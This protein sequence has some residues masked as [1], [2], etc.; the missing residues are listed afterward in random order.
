VSRDAA[1]V[2]GERALASVSL[3][4]ALGGGWEA[5]PLTP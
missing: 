3:V 2:A 5:A 4:R 1:T